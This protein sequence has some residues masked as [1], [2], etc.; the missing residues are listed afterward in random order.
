MN[1]IKKILNAT[2][3]M[4]SSQGY[5]DLGMVAKMSGIPE[6]VVR[7]VITQNGFQESKIIGQFIKKEKPI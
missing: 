7:N 1:D 3:F 6:L 2:N 4:Y 5:I